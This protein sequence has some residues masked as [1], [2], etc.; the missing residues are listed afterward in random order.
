MHV[1]SKNI[2]KAYELLNIARKSGF[3]HSGIFLINDKRVMVEIVGNEKIETIVSKNRKLLVSKEYFY[4]LVKEANEKFKN[5]R[6]RI[7][8]FYKNTFILLYNNINY[9]NN[10]LLFH[11]LFLKIHINSNCM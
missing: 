4:N 6:K 10:H 8:I 3:K 7:D 11:Y 2:E 5:V 1:S 9:R